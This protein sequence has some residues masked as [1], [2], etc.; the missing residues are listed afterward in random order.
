MSVDGAG[1]PVLA[2]VLGVSVSDERRL[3]PRLDQAQGGIPDFEVLVL[4][5]DEHGDDRSL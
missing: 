4:G 1:V 5:A 2:T 3:H